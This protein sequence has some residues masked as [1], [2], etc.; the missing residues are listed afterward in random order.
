LAL[1]EARASEMSELVWVTHAG[2]IRAA[3]FLHHRNGR[4]LI[5]SP[6]DWPREAPAMGQVLELVFDA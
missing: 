3:Q 6:L 1:E 2:V 5:D 4:Q